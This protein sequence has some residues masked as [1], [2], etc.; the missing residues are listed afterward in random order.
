MK[1]VAA[2]ALLSSAVAFMTGPN[3]LNSSALHGRDAYILSCKSKSLT[4]VLGCLRT[5]VENKF[6]HEKTDFQLV[7][8]VGRGTA[9]FL[10]PA[11]A[12]RD[13]VFCSD[14]AAYISWT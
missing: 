13:C 3:R 2:L 14:A 12:A 8:P 9:L 7:L 10:L 1:F 6:R 4:F 11:I 5:D